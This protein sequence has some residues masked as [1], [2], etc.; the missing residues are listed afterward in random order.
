[1][2]LVTLLVFGLAA[3]VGV[4]PAAGAEGNDP[5]R[6]LRAPP[7]AV[8]P[9]H[10]PVPPSAAPGYAPDNGS[11]AL[12][13]IGQPTDE[14]QLFLEHM[15]RARADANA[16]A[17]RLQTTDDPDVLLAYTSQTPEV[18]LGEMT[19]QFAALDQHLP[20]L[21]MNEKLLAA[22][23]LHSQDMYENVFQSHVSSTNP[24][25]PNSPGDTTQKRIE[26]QAYDWQTYAENVFAYAEHV[27]HGHAGFEVDWGGTNW[28]GMQVPPGH[29]LNIHSTV[30]REVG[31]GVVLGTNTNAFDEV[32]PLIVTQD[33]GTPSNDTPFITGVVYVDLNSNGFY[34]VGE[35]L[36]GVTVDVATAACYA[37]SAGSGGYS[38]PVSEGTTV[39][40]AFSGDF[41]AGLITNVTVSGD[42]SVK[43][44][45]VPEYTPPSVAGPTNPISGRTNA[46]TVSPVGGCT[47]YVVRQSEITAAA[48]LEGAESGSNGVLIEASTTHYDVIQSDGV[49]SGSYAFHLA[50]P[51]LAEAEPPDDQFITLDR[52]LFPQAGCTLYFTSRL[53]WATASQVARVQVSADAGGSWSNVYSQA[54]TGGSGESSFVARSVSLAAYEGVPV[55]VRFTYDYV[56]YG[57]YFPET[58]HTVGWCLDDISLSNAEEFAS[59]DEQTIYGATN[60]SFN[61]AMPSPYLLEACGRN[62]NRLFP[63]GPGLRV[64]AEPPPVEIFI[65]DSVR[66]STNAELEIVFLVTN[67]TASA[68]QLL[69]A[70]A[71]DGTYTNVDGLSPEDLGG[72][73]YRFVYPFSTNALGFFQVE[74]QED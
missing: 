43:L 46:Y 57:S 38:V 15:N 41:L 54:G 65:T 27:F 60:F 3:A 10:R 35:G 7:P 62:M 4:L 53:G 39:E 14:E 13:S 18:D 42:A 1:M 63:Y 26:E 66:L 56:P 9:V 69:E 40:V 74:G 16:E 68:L 51:E 70:D 17:L 73:N 45:Y 8:G 19:N 71:V 52:T 64:E 49:A 37:V 2:C 47:N 50:H 25:P 48:W 5:A 24:P 11:P 20:P 32:G 12:Y 61:P 31:V 6:L 67:G 58:W 29:R 36:G 33:F 44:D 21:S 30:L 23:R 22:A 28:H 34:D 72:G 55:T 59:V